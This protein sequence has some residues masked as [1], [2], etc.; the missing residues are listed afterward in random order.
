VQTV[1]GL[2][3]Q[4][5]SLIEENPEFADVEIDGPVVLS[6]NYYGS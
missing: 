6:A 5:Q 4:L 1:K 2:I 3:R